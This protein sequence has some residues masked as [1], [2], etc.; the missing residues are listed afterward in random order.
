MAHIYIYVVD[1]DLGFAPNP[2]HGICTLATCMSRIRSTAKVGDW[3]FGVGGG[4]LKA[5]GKCI[6]A[7]KVTQKLTYNDYWQSPEFYNKKP[8]RNGSKVMM[9]GD[10]IY[11]KENLNNTWLQAH[12]HHSN[13]DGSTNEYNL[14]KDTWSSKVLISKHFFYFGS[15]A[16]FIPPKLLQE[17]GYKNHVGHRVFDYEIAV[18]LVKW[19]EEEYI[20]S[21]NLVLADPFNFDKSESHYSYETNKMS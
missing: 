17:I 21:L 1:R 19:I 13:A 2:F 3:I 16:P 11:F 4:K 7:M 14:R 12:S 5:I 15:S 6:F 10:N 8:L 9:L 20:S 18:N